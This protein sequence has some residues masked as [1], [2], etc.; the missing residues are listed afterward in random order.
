ML[1]V[2][3]LVY[4]PFSFCYFLCLNPGL[5]MVCKYSV[6][7][8]SLLYSFPMN[9]FPKKPWSL[10]VYRTSLL[11]TLW[12]EEKLLVT[13]NFSFS[14]SVFYMFGELYAIFNKFEIVVCELFSLEESKTCYLGKG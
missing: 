2:I 4:F 5:V 14:L 10:R 7:F 1:L 9:P 3:T 12:E 6:Y 13:S 8:F 11:K